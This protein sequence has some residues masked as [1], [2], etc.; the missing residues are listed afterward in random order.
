[1]FNSLVITLRE[2][3]EA[4]LI[5]GIVIS[6]LK[7]SGRI[8]WIRA[9]WWG[10][11]SAV[12]VSIV[13]AYLVRRLEVNEDAYEGWIML[14]GALFV[15]SAMVWMWRTGKHMKQEIE[16][17][18]ISIS[19]TSTR[20]GV[21][22]VF[23]LVFLM[24]A[25]EGAETVVFLGAVSF[26]TTALLNFIGA[27]LG[28]GLA[29]G[30]GVAFFKGALRVDLRKFFN[31]TSLILLV[32]SV[33]LLISGLHELSEAEILPSSRREMAI[34]GP[35]VNNEAFFFIVIIALCLFLFLAGR[36]RASGA[37]SAALS[38][39]PAPERRKIQAEK[40]R[41]QFWKMAMSA[42]SVVIMILI[43]ADY[44]YSRVAQAA[45][46]P[47]KLAISNGV[48]RLPV[49]DLKD[50]RLHHYVVEDGGAPIRFIAILDA[51]GTVHTG[52]DACQICGAKG[53]YQQGQNVICRNCGAAIYLPTIGQQGGCNPIPFPFV[54]E[55]NTMVIAGSALAR[56]AGL[57]R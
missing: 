39:L 27:A 29:I 21:L 45:T 11:G 49:A 44:V 23:L 43:G 1:M 18:L 32:V 37:D 48:V 4:A 16:S 26:E 31:V 35:I 8:E 17:R 56:W 30:L 12:A 6:Y 9:A 42:A 20:A 47:V 36:I 53:Y 38:A 54:V 41:D 15:A 3:L 24:V 22:G 40:R 46:P 51:S 2:G 25:R 55:H 7:K 14:V 50:H 5:V 34:V 52:L 13:M 33:Q 19:S 10:V 57:F 28:L